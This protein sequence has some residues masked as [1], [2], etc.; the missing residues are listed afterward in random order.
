MR[1]TYALIVFAI[2]FPTTIVA[3]QEATSK[4]ITLSIDQDLILFFKGAV[5]LSG[6]FLAAFA[7]IG[8]AFF[9]WD[10]R[11]A[12]ASLLDAQNETK[13]LLEELK[14]DF[15][16]MKDLKEKL[17]QLGAQLEENAEA[18]SNETP[19]STAAGRSNI[20]LIREVIK[21]S[22]YE[23]TTIGRVKK[24]TGLSRDEILDCI[25][26]TADIQIGNGRKTQDF[27]F[28][29]CNNYSS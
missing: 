20:D 24:L 27:I 26:T 7:F 23:W 4:I 28:K 19:V 3:D 1:I 6:I 18:R 13:K 16:A 15:A 21:S 25:R 17:E 8:I 10:V 11:K 29:F 12:R 14:S 5:W 22:S 2:V 9:G